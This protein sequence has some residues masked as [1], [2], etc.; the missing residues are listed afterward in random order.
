MY[1]KNRYLPEQF[2]SSNVNHRVDRYGGSPEAR[3]EFT[4]ELMDE[5]CKT[6][7]EENMAIRLSPF[8]LFNQARGSQ[9]VETWSHLCRELKAR[10]PALSYVSFIEPVSPI[11]PSFPFSSPRRCLIHALALVQVYTGYPGRGKEENH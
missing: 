11:W 7:G 4:L 2:L 8:G 10:H 5:L 1:N 9:R 6:V 3:C